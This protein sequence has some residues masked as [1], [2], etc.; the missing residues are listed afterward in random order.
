M[1]YPS[2]ATYKKVLTDDNVLEN[3][4]SQL[5]NIKNGKELQNVE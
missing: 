1:E 4:T 3:V 2:L 5:L